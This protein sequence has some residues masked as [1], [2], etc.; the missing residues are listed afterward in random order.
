ME[1]LTML[2][3]LVLMAEENT[4][5]YL[6]D[7]ITLAYRLLMEKTIDVF[8]V[9]IIMDTS[10]PGDT[11]GIRLVER[12][13]GIPKY[14]FTPVIFITALE[15]PTMYAYIHLNCTDY[16]QKPY[17]PANLIE[18]VEKALHYSTIR[19]DDI[20]LTFR[21]N[22]ILYPVRLKEIVYMQSLNHIMYI[23]ILNGTVLDIPYKT[24][25]CILQEEDVTDSLLQCSRGVL[26]NREYIYGIDIVNKYL[27]LKD[28][29]G[30]VTISG[31]YKKKLL[32]EF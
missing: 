11:S 28:G 26:V 7:N 30:T 18:V 17:E 19:E 31:K 1:Q 29:F 32:A 25:K 5:V 10:K 14:F 13:R 6:A 12:L 8:L 15:D 3:Q 27:I 20:S 21:K 16:V 2:K 23:H 24:C 22:G 4:E 9:D